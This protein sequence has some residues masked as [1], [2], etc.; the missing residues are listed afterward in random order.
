MCSLC[1]GPEVLLEFN[2]MSNKRK[3]QNFRKNFSLK[4]RLGKRLLKLAL[5]ADLF[6]STLL[7]TARL[8]RLVDSAWEIVIVIVQQNSMYDS[9]LE[10]QSSLPP[11]NTEVAFH[12]IYLPF[13]ALPLML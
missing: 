4:L 3:A 10:T 8:P 1:I 6:R 7:Y 5:P 2:D 9:S 13:A 11:T 12:V